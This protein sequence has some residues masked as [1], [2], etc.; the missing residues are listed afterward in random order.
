[1]SVHC[2]RAKA[3]HCR[4][5]NKTICAQKSYQ[6]SSSPASHHVQRSPTTWSSQLGRRTYTASQT[7]QQS[8]PARLCVCSTSRETRVLVGSGVWVWLTNAKV[9][10]HAQGNTN[11]QQ[12]STAADL[13]RS[14][15]LLR[16]PRD[17]AT[18]RGLRC[19]GD[20]AG[21]QPKKLS[22]IS[23]CGC[24]CTAQ[25]DQLIHLTIL[26]RL[27]R[28]SHSKCKD[29]CEQRSR[30]SRSSQCKSDVGRDNHSSSQSLTG[31]P[32]M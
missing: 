4:D 15:S 18:L 16:G 22:H 24:E 19:Q 9:R 32:T 7:W 1:M 14:A 2:L 12:A 29:W 17:K 26:V 11:T 20:C 8:D 27:H 3:G 5:N 23:A 13:Q 30:Y 25:Q 21:G 10:M 6:H 28:C 31:K